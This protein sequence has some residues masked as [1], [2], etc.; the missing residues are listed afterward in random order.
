ME[1]LIC[2]THRQ[3]CEPKTYEMR[4]MTFYSDSATAVSL[5]GPTMVAAKGLEEF[6]L[7]ESSILLETVTF[8]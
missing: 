5:A 8:V 2:D 3:I 4:M 6:W 1:I 7:F